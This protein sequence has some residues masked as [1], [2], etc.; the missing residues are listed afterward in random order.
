MQDRVINPG[1]PVE[2][3]VARNG[4]KSEA[5]LSNMSSRVEISR[6]LVLFNSAS[7]LVA[8]GL[9]VTVLDW[10]HRFLLKRIGT[11]EY[12]MPPVLYSIM[13]FAPLLTTM[14][15]N[16]LVRYTTKVYT[17]GDT[18]R[19]TQIVSTMSLILLGVVLVVV[20]IGSLVAYRLDS[21]FEER[22]ET[23]LSPVSSSGGSAQ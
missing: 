15:T 12:S 9:N 2:R 23:A 21:V 14:F 6:K 16:G 20:F 11:E 13:M 7:S 17:A 10:L 1:Q 8:L 3:C 4:L 5:S 18:H 19:V 22:T